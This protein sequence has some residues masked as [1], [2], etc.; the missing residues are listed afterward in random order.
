MHIKRGRFW[1]SS[2]I[3]AALLFSI[4][5]SLPS[6][7]AAG[8]LPDWAKSATI[9][10]V[11][12]RQ[13]TKAG[14][15]NA[16]SASLPRLKT[17]GVKILWL[18]PVQPISK[19]NRKG[20]LGS[21]YSIADYKGINPEY[22]S[23][24]DF[25]ALVNKAHDLGFK[26]ILDWVANHS[27]WDNSWTANK[28]WYHTDS[29]GKIIAPN[30]DWTDVAWLNYENAD[31]RAAMIDAMSYW[32]K[33]FDIDGFRADVASGPPVSFWEEANKKL[34]GIK[35][36]F[37]LAE[38]Q[39]N[40][41]LLNNAFVT[42]YNWNLL[43]TMNA[44]AKGSRNK[45]DF[46]IEA[47]HLILN[48][49]AGSFPMN[50][51]TNHDENSWNGTEFQRLGKGVEAFSALYFTYPG[52]PLIYSG[53]ETGNTKQIAFFEKDLIPGLT[54]ANSISG[55]YSKLISLKNRN[56]ALWND[57]AAPLEPLDGNNKEVIAYQRTLGKDKVITILNISGVSQKVTLKIGSLAGTYKLLTS[58]KSGALAKSTSLTLKPWQYEVYST[59]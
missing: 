17:L 7:Q 3:S 55:F 18:M 23:D 25:A 12:M 33:K 39:N 52:I 29:S 21:P 13:Y 31:M 4:F 56:T 36:L 2:I 59:N 22:G 35:P 47:S 43:G 6:A 50:F 28:D 5:T 15:F 53:Q 16:F 14:T 41:D 58:G 32:V 1:L 46:E 57:S 48:Y 9:Y 37:M 24:A 20:T 49:P 40:S 11:N 30:N 34:Q 54:K 44:I 19:L 51:I 27:G 38:D 8:V 42:N 10:E 45:V 26:I